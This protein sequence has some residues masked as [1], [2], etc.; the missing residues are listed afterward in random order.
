MN[1]NIELT[2]CASG[3]HIQ[4]DK[5]SGFTTVFSAEKSFQLK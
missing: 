2:T 5:I 4:N 1:L 3:F